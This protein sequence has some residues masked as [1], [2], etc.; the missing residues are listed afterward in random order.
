MQNIV[1]NMTWNKKFHYDRSRNDRALG[2]TW[3][4]FPQ[5]LPTSGSG[6]ESLITART[7]RTTLVAH[8]DQFPGLKMMIMM[9]IL[10][11]FFIALSSRHCHGE[12]SRGSR[13]ECR[14]APDRNELSARPFVRPS[15]HHTV[16][17][18]DKTVVTY[19]H[20][21]SLPRCIIVSL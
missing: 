4:P 2:S 16:Q 17:R 18:C 11:T 20:H 6:M 9:M 5:A 8:E 7:R 13:D 3:S 14:T 15:V 10:R 1:V 12:S 19:Y 21:T